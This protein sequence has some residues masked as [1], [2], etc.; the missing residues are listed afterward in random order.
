MWWLWFIIG[1]VYC[2]F[3]VTYGV[4]VGKFLSYG[5]KKINC[6]SCLQRKN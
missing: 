4:F 3:T 5:S 6:C 2:S 1:V